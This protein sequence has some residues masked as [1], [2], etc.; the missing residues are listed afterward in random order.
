MSNHILNYK[1]EKKEVNNMYLE[2]NV[3]LSIMTWNIYQGADFAPIFTATKPE[4]IPVRVTEVFRQFLA[5]NFPNRARAIARQ[6]ILQEPDI[7]GLQESVLIKLIPPKNIPCS[8]EVVYDFLDILLNVLAN[9]GLHYRIAVVHEGNTTELPDSSGNTISFTDRE[10][11]LVRE[12]CKLKIIRTQEEDF[13]TNLQVNIAGQPFTVIRG[14][15]SIDA[16]FKGHKFRLVNTHLE[17]LSPRVQVAQANELLAGPGQTK[18]P[19]I[20]I[21][22]FNSNANGSGTPTYGNLIAAGFEDTWLIAGKGDGFTCCQDADLLNAQSKLTE[23]IDL[24]LIKNK[25]DWNIVKDEL[26]GEAQSDRTFTR[27]WPSDHA[28]VIAEFKMKNC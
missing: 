22:D 20:F 15:T 6:I 24:I 9:K 1:I 4:Q 13:K 11:I 28:G 19:L 18:R 17:P 21:G 14:W 8:H 10:A 7:I 23:R 27:L 3:P 12:D 2:R 26:V 5:T 16:Y 25:D